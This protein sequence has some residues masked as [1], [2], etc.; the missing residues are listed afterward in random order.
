MWV[1]A[2]SSPCLSRLLPVPHGNSIYDVL[3]CGPIYAMQAAV[4]VYHVPIK[5]R[6]G[7]I[8]TKVKCQS[9]SSPF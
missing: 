4:C 2:L 7:I 9:V 5:C 6:I 3:P 1:D 8:A